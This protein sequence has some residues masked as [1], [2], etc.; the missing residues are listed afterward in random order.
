MQVGAVVN[1]H[2][3][4][5]K[6]AER[7][8]RC[9]LLALSSDQ[10][11]EVVAAVQAARRALAIAGLDIYALASAIETG[12][13][14]PPPAVDPAEPYRPRQE[15]QEAPRDWRAEVKFC[16]RHRDHLFGKEP[17]LIDTLM[18]WK[19]MPTPRQMEWLARIV[20]RIRVN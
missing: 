19:G 6:L 3:P 2:Q 14:A 1:Y 20:A 4:Q 12:L 10:D 13:Q 11:G 18:K 5:P 17:G 7:I 16:H 15:R 8:A 9:L